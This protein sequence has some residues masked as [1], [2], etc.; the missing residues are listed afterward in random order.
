MQPCVVPIQMLCPSLRDKQR[1]MLIGTFD[2][3]LVALWI[4]IPLFGLRG[5]ET[6]Y[7]FKFKKKFPAL[8]RCN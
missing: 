4:L 5:P 1:V 3:F 7:F 8:L 6:S 2:P